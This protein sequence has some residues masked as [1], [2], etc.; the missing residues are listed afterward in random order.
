MTS[1]RRH[2]RLHLLAAAVLAWP[3]LSAVAP[4]GP[5]V[6]TVLGDSIAAGYGLRAADALPAQLQ[7]ALARLGVTAQVRGAGVSGD[8]TAGALARVGFSVQTDTRVCV[9]ELGG[10]DFLQSISPAQTERSL[11]GIIAKLQTRKIAV[12][13]A[14][15]RLPARTAGAYGREFAALYPRVARAT[16]VRLAPDLLAGVLG[17]PAML[18]VDGL[19]PN[20]AGVRLVAARLAPVV[21]AALR[22]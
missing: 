16:H 12:V 2:R 7:T 1:A 19:H 15:A 18:Q 8:T 13:L 21:A 14:G 9:I 17:A 22:R 5:P 3:G 6:V 20:P 11:R 4:A 10:N